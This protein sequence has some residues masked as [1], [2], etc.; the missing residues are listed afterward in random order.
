VIGL[1]DARTGERCCAVA[2]AKPGA[3]PALADLARFCADAGLARQKLPEQLELVDALP[4]NS[5]GKVLQHE[6]RRRFGAGAN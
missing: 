6:L 3:V 5:S 2:V 1:P 4:H